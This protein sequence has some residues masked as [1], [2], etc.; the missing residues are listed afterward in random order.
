[1]G[2]SSKSCCCS[3]G[4]HRRRRRWRGAWTW[5]DDSSI[6]SLLQESEDAD[7]CRAS[8]HVSQHQP[9]HAL[10]FI[11]ALLKFSSRLDASV[12]HGSVTTNRSASVLLNRK[13]WNFN[14]P[15]LPCVP[16]PSMLADCTR[17]RRRRGR[18]RCPRGGGLAAFL[19][20]CLRAK[21]RSRSSCQ[22]GQ[23]ALESLRGVNQE[24]LWEV[25]WA[26]VCWDEA[27]WWLL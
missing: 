6:S 13:K 18:R 26:A 25:A 23:Q 21:S 22:S 12:T 2:R 24:T 8:C 4:R 9:G 1:M 11:A 20:L 10:V 15:P 16:W 27:R 3:W 19:T 14:T 7:P 17:G 5:T